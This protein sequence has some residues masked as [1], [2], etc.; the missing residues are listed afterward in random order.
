MS[1][2]ALNST[3]TGGEEGLLGNDQT[4]VLFPYAENPLVDLFSDP[5]DLQSLTLKSI[6]TS[7]VPMPGK[8]IDGMDLG[9]GNLD[10]GEQ[11]I[12]KKTYNS[13]I[14]SIKYLAP[15]CTMYF[16]LAGVVEVYGS[17][18]KV[19]P[20]FEGAP[21]ERE[22]E[23]QLQDAM[24]EPEKGSITIVARDSSIKTGFSPPG[25]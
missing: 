8:G 15:S 22:V 2:Q 14:S 3:K 10:P 9:Q 19:S 7:P 1:S 25:P 5:S 6:N 13:L 16:A 18:N 24:G 23:K 4:A 21:V 20:H 11:L 17:W 12:Y